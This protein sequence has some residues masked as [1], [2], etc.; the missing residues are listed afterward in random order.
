MLI[1]IDKKQKLTNKHFE[2]VDEEH[3]KAI[4]IYNENSDDEILKLQQQLDLEIDELE[5]KTIEVVDYEI[6][7]NEEKHNNDYL[8]KW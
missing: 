5:K 6:K 4:A 8:K 7:D 1:H 2:K 3:K